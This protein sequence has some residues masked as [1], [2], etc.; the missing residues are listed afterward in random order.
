MLNFCTLFDN[1]YLAKGVAMLRSL[2]AHCPDARVYVLCMDEAVREMLGQ[3]AMPEV[4]CLS[5]AEV[6]DETVLAV[7]PGR[8]RA[9]YCW[10]LSPCLPWHLL[11]RHAEIDLIT[12]LDADLYFYSA[13]QPLFDEIGSASITVIEHRFVPL[14]QHLESRGRFCVEWVSFR[15]DAEGLA[16]LKRWREQC[17]EWC[18]YRL[19]ADRMGDQKYLDKWPQQYRSLHVLQHPGAGVAP[20]NY[21]RYRFDRDSAGRICVDDV[22]L[23]FYHFHQFQLLSN[24]GF[25]RLSDYYSRSGPVP[26]MVYAEYERCIRRVMAELRGLQSG[27]SGGVRPYLEVKTQ[28]LVQRLASE[29]LKRWLKRLVRAV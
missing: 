27:F 16:C 22:P 3:L 26:D 28:R 10:T 21:A 19:E 7:K 12:Y 5:L 4:Y 13:I 15:R 2:Q 1:N 24:G 9:E 18:F 29:W 20:W 17:I 6:E 14:F 23:I 11:E 25:D 8:S